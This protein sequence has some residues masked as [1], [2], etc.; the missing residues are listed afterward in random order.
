MIQQYC[1]LTGTLPSYPV[2]A[3]CHGGPAA[4]D[5]QGQPFHRHQQQFRDDVDFGV[6]Q[7]RA[8]DLVLGGSPP[9]F[10]YWHHQDDL[11]DTALAR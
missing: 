2:V 11:S 6:G 10:L 4:L 1:L 9:A 7:P 5:E 8:L 3:L